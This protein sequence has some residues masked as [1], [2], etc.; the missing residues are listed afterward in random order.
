M[1]QDDRHTAPMS[2]R[3]RA[4]AC[5]LAAT[6]ALAVT[7]TP[8]SSSEGTTPISLTGCYLTAMQFDDDPDRLRQYVPP[9]YTLGGPASIA[10]ASGTPQPPD[11]AAF[12]LWT[13]SCDSATVGATGVGAADLVLV[14]VVIEK[15]D[16]GVVAAQPIAAYDH[17]LTSA[18][19]DNE[20]LATALR[21]NG[22]PAQHVRQLT[23]D[24]TTNGAGVPATT[25]TV[26]RPGDGLSFS[27]TPVVDHTATDHPHDNSFWHGADPATAAELEI[28][29][30][31]ARD[32]FCLGEG[33]GRASAPAG[34]ATAEF[35][36]MPE[37]RDPVFA[38]DHLQLGI[39]SASVRSS[40]G[41]G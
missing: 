34:S 35:L 3:R 29:V 4:A 13:H 31:G 20:R 37:R 21:L 2:R 23:F 36:G 14:G 27:A 24:R 41:T 30:R 32:W 16:V 38:A 39:V 12:T 18:A 11:R 28:R 7:A 40:T 19:T 25:T 15:P 26:P 8:G 1:D 17:Y 33:C 9:A 5:S 6:A 10:M 22:L